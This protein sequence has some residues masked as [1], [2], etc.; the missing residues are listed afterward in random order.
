MRRIHPLMLIAA[1]FF[2]PS[3]ARTERHFLRNVVEEFALRAIQDARIGERVSLPDAIFRQTSADTSDTQLAQLAA[4]SAA[5][6]N[7]T[8][9]RALDM[10]RVP[11]EL[12]TTRGAKLGQEFAVLGR[13]F[14]YCN[15]EEG[16]CRLWIYLY[17]DGHYSKLLDIEDAS[18]FGFV[19]SKSVLPLLIVWT[20]LS[21]TERGARVFHFYAGQYNEA[22]AW[23]ERY[24]YADDN[25]FNDEPYVHAAPKIESRF[26]PGYP[27][28]D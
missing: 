17:K 11:V 22:G 4:K 14:C 15:A 27:V 26:P 1:L 8:H 3:T 16:N 28:P 24:E 7:A 20:Q 12:L 9:R 10:Y 6:C 23:V 13:G 25:P 21:P 19:P 18:T 5:T 2:S